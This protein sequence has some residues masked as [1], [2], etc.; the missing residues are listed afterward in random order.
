MFFDLQTKT[1]VPKNLFACLISNS[2]IWAHKRKESLSTQFIFKLSQYFC[3]ISQS[4]RLR[5]YALKLVFVFWGTLRRKADV[6]GS[7]CNAKHYIVVVSQ[8]EATE[9]NP[10]DQLIKHVKKT[11]VMKSLKQFRTN[12]NYLAYMSDCMIEICNTHTTNF[13]HQKH[14]SHNLPSTYI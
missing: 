7:C 5:C 12:V 4:C 13:G 11:K 14:F 6:Y 8:S 9:N 3:G 2:I 10:H 1:P